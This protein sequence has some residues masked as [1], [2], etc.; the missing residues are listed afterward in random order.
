MREAD[1]PQQ[2][3]FARALLDA[4]PEEERR[5]QQR[6]GHEK[7]AEVG[8]VLAEVGR[9]AGRGQAVGPHVLNREA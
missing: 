9:A 4:E 8:E 5:Q 3:D 2:A 1:R 6:R 7:E